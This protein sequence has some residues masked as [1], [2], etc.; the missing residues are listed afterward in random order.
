LEV[1]GVSGVSGTLLLE[2]K[3][4][5]VKTGNFNILR[6]FSEEFPVPFSIEE[7]K[8]ALE[9]A[10]ERKTLFDITKLIE[11]L[12][13][14]QVEPRSLEYRDILFHETQEKFN[15]NREK[16][17]QG[18]AS[19]DFLTHFTP[20]PYL[21][22]V[23]KTGVLSNIDQ[24]KLFGRSNSGEGNDLQRLTGRL[25]AV[26]VIDV[27]KGAN[28]GDSDSKI[29]EKMLSDIGR[30][31]R[32]FARD[33]YPYNPARIFRGSN[34]PTLRSPSDTNEGVQ[35]EAEHFAEEVAMYR[36]RFSEVIY[37][38]QGYEERIDPYEKNGAP[39]YFNYCA[40]DHGKKT[41]RLS[42]YSIADEFHADFFNEW[43]DDKEELL[44]SIKQLMKEAY[45]ESNR[46]INNKQDNISDFESFLE[47]N[48]DPFDK[49]ILVLDPSL[50][51][52]FVQSLYDGESLVEGSVSPNKILGS[53]GSNSHFERVCYN[54][55]KVILDFVDKEAVDY[56]ADDVLFETPN[57]AILV[58]NLYK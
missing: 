53:I 23:L 28:L 38:R 3:A 9:V 35:F 52:T 30:L 36:E 39:R 21:D 45:L 14:D 47:R 13:E 24:I 18:V 33:K 50:E 55:G 49:T 27:F 54:E 7:K 11:E 41:V 51:R 10:I 44:N 26:S 37:S 25:D 19:R 2:L 57:G 15:E 58:R 34:R 48:L 12:G 1:L 16:L 40:I 4:S 20:V 56:V 46:D 29:G 5:V 43:D 8:A 31:K 17:R 32:S 22:S 42:Q 6:K